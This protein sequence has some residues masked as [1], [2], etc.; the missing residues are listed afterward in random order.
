MNRAASFCAIRFVSM[1]NM[2]ITSGLRGRGRRSM[3]GGTAS[4]R[5]DSTLSCYRRRVHSILSSFLYLRRHLPISFSLSM[6]YIN[7]DGF[8]EQEYNFREFEKLFASKSKRV[9]SATDLTRDELVQQLSTLGAY[10]EIAHS[11]IDVPFVLQNL[12]TLCAPGFPLEGYDALRD[13][14]HVRSV[15]STIGEHQGYCATIPSTKTAL[16]AFSGTAHVAVAFRLVW[17][18]KTRFVQKS[19]PSK[20]RLH[21]GFQK[22]YAAELRAHARKAL[23]DAFAEL[24]EVDTLILTGHSLGGTL[25]QFMLLEILEDILGTPAASSASPSPSDEED[26]PWRKNPP[27]IVCTT[28]GS[29]R[30]GNK[31]FKDYYA[32]RV[33]EYREKTGKDLKHWSVV[34]HRD[35]VPATP[36]GFTPVTS[37]GETF[38]L[39]HGDLYNVSSCTVGLTQGSDV[40]FRHRFPSKRQNIPSSKSSAMNLG[41]LDSSTGVTTTTLRATWSD[42]FTAFVAFG[43]TEMPVMPSTSVRNGISSVKTSSVWYRRRRRRR[44]GGER[45]KAWTP[46]SK[47]C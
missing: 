22:V 44:H 19:V 14:K 8:F 23:K 21:Y 1:T 18:W 6:P 26:W 40:R 38:Y 9:L 45:A 42:F 2:L 46:H 29:P 13:L 11:S 15:H 34:G 30:P 12:D 3:R 33:E 27:N 47:P 35:G 20:A 25:S 17:I 41:Q 16:L 7:S 4:R 31:T 10:A 24:G 5:P 39:Y 28:F 36:P 32:K 37:V 43:K